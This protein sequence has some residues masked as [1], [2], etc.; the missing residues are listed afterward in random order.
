MKF[1]ALLVCLSLI[2]TASACRKKPAPAPVAA[3]APGVVT[4]N[5]AQLAA[6]NASVLTLMLQEFVQTNGRM[7]NDISELAAIKTFGPPPKAPT[8][9]KFVIDAKTKQV[10]A[11]PQ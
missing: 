4:G 1:A 7:P 5:E 3:P 6:S 8:G 11:L 10:V 9:Y 2:L